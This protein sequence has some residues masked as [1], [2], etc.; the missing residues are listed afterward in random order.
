MPYEEVRTEML[1]TVR[2]SY[3]FQRCLRILVHV[4]NEALRP[5]KTDAAS[6][7]DDF[8]KNIKIHQK[9]LLEILIFVKVSKKSG[10]F[11]KPLFFV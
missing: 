5:P 2:I 10:A 4:F 1:I 6:D 7:A 8:F 9:F 11:S 3:F